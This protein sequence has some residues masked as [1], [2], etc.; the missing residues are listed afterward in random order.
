MIEYGVVAVG[1][2]GLFFLAMIDDLSF[3]GRVRKALIW[4]FKRMGR[5]R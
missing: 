5:G 1:V 2:P 4:K 3:N